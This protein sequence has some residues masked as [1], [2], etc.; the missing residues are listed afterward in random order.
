MPTRVLAKTKESTRF[1]PRTKCTRRDTVIKVKITEKSV[2]R[3]ASVDK[4]SKSFILNLDVYEKIIKTK[5]IV[6]IVE[7]K[8]RSSK[9]VF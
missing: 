9:G 6:L 5:A 7:T 1:K 8:V 2:I 4:E 3:P